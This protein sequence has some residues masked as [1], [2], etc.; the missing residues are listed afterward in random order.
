MASRGRL[1]IDRLLFGPELASSRSRIRKTATNSTQGTPS[2]I[3]DSI[4]KGGVNAAVQ[5]IRTPSTRS[6]RS[7]LHPVVSRWQTMWRGPYATWLPTVLQQRPLVGITALCVTIGCIFASLAILVASDGQAVK[8]WSIQ[9]TVYLA[10]V[11]AIAN[12]SLALARLEAVPV[13][14]TVPR[15]YHLL[16]HVARPRPFVILFRDSFCSWL[17]IMVVFYL[18]WSN[19]RFT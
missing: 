10:I 3:S 2:P 18:T 8:A 15:V 14:F 5:G 7:D 19:Y 16:S 13:S 1:T 12:M 9:P 6:D 4:E 11:T 17:G